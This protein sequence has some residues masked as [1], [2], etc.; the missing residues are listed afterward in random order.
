MDLIVLVDLEDTHDR[1]AVTVAGE[2]HHAWADLGRFVGVGEGR[3]A[4][5]VVVLGVQVGDNVNTIMA[6][7]VTGRVP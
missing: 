6:P 7:R 4:E 2:E 3:P 1:P 5:A